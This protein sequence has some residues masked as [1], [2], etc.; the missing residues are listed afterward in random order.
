[1]RSLAWFHPVCF[2]PLHPEQ[3]YLEPPPGQPMMIGTLRFSSLAY[4]K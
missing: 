4:D 2:A 1:M 3:A